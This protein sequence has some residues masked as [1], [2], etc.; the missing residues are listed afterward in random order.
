MALRGRQKYEKGIFVDY[1]LMIS[2]VASAEPTE[3]TKGT[4]KITGVIEAK[5]EGVPK[6]VIY[7]KHK[8]GK[9]TVYIVLEKENTEGQ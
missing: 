1:R 7:R 8:S 5:L 9:H 2:G 4:L 3:V 6:T